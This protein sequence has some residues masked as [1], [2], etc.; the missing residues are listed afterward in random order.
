METTL[1]PIAC[2][3]APIATVPIPCE[4]PFLLLLEPIAIEFQPD[5]VRL[6]LPIA[7][8]LPPTEAGSLPSSSFRPACA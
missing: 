3:P 4:P 7:S 6:S 2:I 5:A 1:R 8:C